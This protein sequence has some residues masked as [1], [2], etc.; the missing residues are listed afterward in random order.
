MLRSQTVSVESSLGPAD[1]ASKISN[2]FARMRVQLERLQE[3]EEEDDPS[4]KEKASLRQPVEERA[5]SPKA[6]LVVV[7]NR[8]QEI[9]F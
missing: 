5:E 8:L 1:E 3:L 9:L 2:L 6:R 7:N 4:E